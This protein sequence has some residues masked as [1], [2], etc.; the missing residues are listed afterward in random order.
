MPNSG[1]KVITESIVFFGSGPVAAASLELLAKTFTIEAVVTKPKPPHH[2]GLVPVIE[3]VEKLNIPIL[4]TAD[5]AEVSAK[6]TKA[7]LR[8]R[9]A[10]LIDFGIIIKQDVIDTFPLGIVNSHF[11]L[12]PE[13]RGA[14]PITFAILSGQHRTGISLMLLV[15]AMDEGPLLAQV[16]YDIPPNETTPSLTEVLIELSYASLREILPLYL[17][18]SVTPAP[19]EAVSM[20]TNP[21]PTYSRK[22]TKADGILDFSKPAK[23]LEC[24]IRAY[25]EWPK[26]HATIA[27]KDVIITAA[28]I[29][30]TRMSGVNAGTAF[31]QNKELLIQT[32]DGALAVDSL[33]PAGKPEM[34]AAAF[35]TGY[36]RNI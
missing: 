10:V 31:I 36:G 8:S 19:Q 20:A 4:T 24:E 32:S 34:T 29:A 13:W 12:L 17:S 18:G 16:P 33:K 5:K 6:I 35:V 1:A 3:L 27:G 25:L 9:V 23:Q 26:N 11:S 30:A 7:S 22:L 28:H 2:R 21:G 15:E 14:D